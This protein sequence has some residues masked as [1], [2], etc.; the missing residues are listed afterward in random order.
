MGSYGIIWDLW[1][2]DS[3][4]TPVFMYIYSIRFASPGGPENLFW[5]PWRLDA[6]R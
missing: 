5:S 4:V 1:V 2:C 6:F 3:L